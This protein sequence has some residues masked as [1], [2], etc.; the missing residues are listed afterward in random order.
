MSSSPGDHFGESDSHRIRRPIFG[1]KQP[2]PPGTS[3]PTTLSVAVSS[4]G[5]RLQSWQLTVIEPV[6]RVDGGNE[7]FTLSYAGNTEVH[8]P[9]L[10]PGSL[11]H[12]S[13]RL[14]P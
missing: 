13:T 2:A 5:F 10:F 14:S 4:P 7:P 11:N 6:E 9:T 3:Q 12:W 8:L 1:S